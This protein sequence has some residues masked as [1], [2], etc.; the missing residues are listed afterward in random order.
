MVIGCPHCRRAP[1]GCASFTRDAL[2]YVVR[3]VRDVD[4]EIDVY[5]ELRARE[6]ADRAAY[7]LLPNTPAEWRQ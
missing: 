3:S 1:C 5:A 4:N 7:R 6:R 2:G